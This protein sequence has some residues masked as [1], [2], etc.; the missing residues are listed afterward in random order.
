MA[1]HSHGI[2]ELARHGAQHRYAELKSE[3]DSLLRHFPDLETIGRK[4][5]Q[6]SRSAATAIA[7]GRRAFM[8]A[9]THRGAKEEAEDVCKSSEGHRRR[10]AE[11]MGEAEGGVCDWRRQ[12]EEIVAFREANWRRPHG[13]ARLRD[14][15]TLRAKSLARSRTFAFYSPWIYSAF[16]RLECRFSRGTIDVIRA[17]LE[18]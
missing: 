16:R 12:D 8:D 18:R 5:G 1:K 9:V 14:A 2:L 3:L 4:G 6:V 11:A 15:G 17:S 13:C 10:A 7:K